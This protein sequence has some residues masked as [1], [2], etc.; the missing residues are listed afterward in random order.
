MFAVFGPRPYRI[1]V[2]ATLLLF[3]GLTPGAAAE[4]FVGGA[5]VDIT[6]DGPVALWGQMHTRISNGVESKVTATVLA[7]ESRADGKSGEKAILVACDLV[8]IPVEALEQVRAQVAARLADFPVQKIVLSA[9]HTHTAPVL[10]EGVYEIPRDVMQP[11]EYVEFFAKRVADGIVS[12]WNSRQPGKVGWGMGHAVVAQNR[13]KYLRNIADVTSAAAH[14]RR[15]FTVYDLTGTHIS[16]TPM[17]E[18]G[19]K[20]SS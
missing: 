5:T 4:L 18:C 17:P 14:L 1:Y 7:L 11:T 9:T 2:L 6:P 3:V 20:R 12:A 16:T 13:R 10:T 8:M 19:S 15:R